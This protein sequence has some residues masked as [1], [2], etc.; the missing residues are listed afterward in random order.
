MIVGII[1]L[2]KYEHAGPDPYSGMHELRAT[3]TGVDNSALVEMGTARIGGQHVT[4]ILMEGEVKGQTVIGVN[5]LTGSRKWT[6]F[7]I[8]AIPSLWLCA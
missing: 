1:G 6:K 7:S 8:P 4:A 2:L 3:V 5:Q